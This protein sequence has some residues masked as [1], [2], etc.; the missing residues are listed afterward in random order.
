[1]RILFLWLFLAFFAQSESRWRIP[2]DA[3]TTEIPSRLISGPTP[4]T[5]F[6]TKLQPG[7]KLSWPNQD[8]LYSMETVKL[9]PQM[10]LVDDELLGQSYDLYYFAE[11]KSRRSFKEEFLSEEYLFFAKA[12][13]GTI[14]E[15]YFN[16]KLLLKTQN[17]LS[18]PLSIFK[19]KEG[20][21]CIKVVT[22]GGKNTGLIDAYSYVNDLF[23]IVNGKEVSVNHWSFKENSLEALK[24]YE[25]KQEIDIEFT[26]DETFYHPKAG[27][28]SSDDLAKKEILFPKSKV[29]FGLSDDFN[30]RKVHKFS[31][32]KELEN[33]FERAA[34]K[35]QSQTIYAKLYINDEYLTEIYPNSKH[36]DLDLSF[37]SKGKHKVRLEGFALSRMSEVKACEFVEFK[38][39]FSLYSKGSEED[40]ENLFSP[41]GR[42]ETY[43]K[44][45]LQFRF[46]LKEEDLSKTFYLDFSRTV[47]QSLSSWK[48]GKSKLPKFISLNGQSI[49]FNSSFVIL[50]QF[51]VL[52]WNTISFSGENIPRA[53]ITLT[54]PNRINFVKTEELINRSDLDQDKQYSSYRDLS[55]SPFAPSYQ[56]L[57]PILDESESLFPRQR[58]KIFTLSYRLPSGFSY[59][60]LAKELSERQAFLKLNQGESV[61]IKAKNYG[62]SE[63]VEFLL[64]LEAQGVSVDWKKKTLNDYKAYVNKHAKHWGTFQ[65]IKGSE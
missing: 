43:S 59:L 3:L 28:L 53:K 20:I 36:E 65:K 34:L 60:N 33:H 29:F 13:E 7:Q 27:F 10:E 21:I 64:Y 16:N 55:F 54:K 6:L 11:L 52:G 17:E 42:S 38:E 39:Q 25:L 5:W 61:D 32:E 63:L 15:L 58:K 41:L 1:M 26:N 30:L 45:D 35:L 9:T 4:G 62:S 12:D 47:S 8:Q 57:K 22:A 37:L 49:T 40:L 24:M 48:N 46:F 23:A 50:P 31:Y 2:G 19:D 14:L 51:L 44:K 56:F 18:F